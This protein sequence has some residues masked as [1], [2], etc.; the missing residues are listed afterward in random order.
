MVIFL[1]ITSAIVFVISF[2]ASMEDK[3]FILFRFSSVDYTN[4]SEQN[5]LETIRLATQ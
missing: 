1:H 2:L 3:T 4:V 5:E